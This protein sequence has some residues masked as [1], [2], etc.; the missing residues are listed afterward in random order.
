MPTCFGTGLPSSGTFIT[1]EYKSNK[2]VG[3]ILYV[4]IFR[5]TC[6][7]CS[8]VVGQRIYCGLSGNAKSVH[9]FYHSV[10]CKVQSVMK[11]TKMVQ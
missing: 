11:L 1:K 6:L 7:P 5:E 8:D 10:T 4:N 2:D 3:L 9:H